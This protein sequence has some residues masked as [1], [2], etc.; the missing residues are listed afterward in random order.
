[1]FKTYS[2]CCHYDRYFL[3]YRNKQLNL[4]L[5]LYTRGLEIYASVREVLKVLQERETQPFSLS[6]TAV[7]WERKPT[8]STF[9]CLR[10]ALG[11]QVHFASCFGFV[12]LLLL[13]FCCFGGF[14]WLLF[15]WLVGFFCYFVRGLFVYFLD[16]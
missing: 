12:V 6:N 15:Y 13:W 2:F 9:C 1:M 11:G 7:F 10:A 5:P 16:S 4:Y 14:F 3:S 8:T